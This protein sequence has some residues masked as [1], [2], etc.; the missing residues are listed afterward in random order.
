MRVLLG[1][2]ERQG[3]GAVYPASGISPGRGL[4]GSGAAA[5]SHS[6]R[7]KRWQ[8]PAHTVGRG[9]V[10]G[11]SGQQQGALQAS[12]IC[13]LSSS[14]CCFPAYSCRDHICIVSRSF[15]HQDENC[16][17]KPHIS[18]CYHNWQAR[19]PCQ[20][21]C[22]NTHSRDHPVLGLA[23]GSCSTAG[24]RA[25]SRQVKRVTGFRKQRLPP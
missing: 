9:R 11:A 24:A 22:Q 21:N 13:I 10:T 4:L 1:L 5:P 16:K 18:Y 8:S 23:T 6:P 25:S 17:R 2:R 15:G 3:R 20:R 12:V 7:R 19:V 14:P